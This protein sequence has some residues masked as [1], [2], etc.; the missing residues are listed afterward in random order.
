[1]LLHSNLASL[2]AVLYVLEPTLA[3]AI[4]RPQAYL[5]IDSSL[6]PQRRWLDA[7]MTGLRFFRR[8]TTASLVRITERG[9]WC[10]S[11]KFYP[12]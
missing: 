4:V 6:A 10:L 12:A 9:S 1:M 5:G 7:R 2:L 11:D 8:K 3:V